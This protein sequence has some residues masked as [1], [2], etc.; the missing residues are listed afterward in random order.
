MH[1]SITMA[2]DPTTSAR[3]R[4][5]MSNRMRR[6]E[7]QVQREIDT[8]QRSPGNVVPYV[9]F[10]RVVR[11]I[12]AT[13]GTKNMRSDAM[14]ALQCATEGRMTEMFSDALRLATYQKRDTV[15]HTDIQF[16]IPADERP[17]VVVETS[18]STLFPLPE[19]VQ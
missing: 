14:R 6:R 7:R 13:H 8:L 10:S 4:K 2:K 12:L 18:A 1:N 5:I 9:S 3:K 16:V 19:P 17:A 11:E 15:V